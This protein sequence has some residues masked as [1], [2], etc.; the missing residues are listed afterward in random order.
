MR[1]WRDLAWL[2]G[3]YGQIA[4][5]YSRVFVRTSMR[6]MRSLPSSG[7][8]TVDAAHKHGIWVGVCGEMA[9]DP[10][11]TPLLLGL[12]VDELSVAPANVPQIKFLT[13][14]LKCSEAQELAE[15]A[16]NSESGSEVLARAEKY[17]REIAPGMFGGDAPSV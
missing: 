8:M 3:I 17:V 5:D 6:D 9:A 7:S 2:Q 16:L 10:V 13:R 12:G 14:R 1:L 15:F 11:M 4:F